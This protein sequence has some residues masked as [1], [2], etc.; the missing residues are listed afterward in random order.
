MITPYVVCMMIVFFL[1]RNVPFYCTFVCVLNMSLMCT[2]KEAN[3]DE[4]DMDEETT[5]TK[6]E[7]G[8]ERMIGV[9]NIIIKM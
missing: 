6:L 2:S 4:L 5:R 1:Q 8:Q 7:K 9:S 3:N